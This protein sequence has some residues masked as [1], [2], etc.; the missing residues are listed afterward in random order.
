MLCLS[1]YLYIYYIKIFDIFQ[2]IK[3]VGRQRLELW[4]PAL[5]VL[6][7]TNWAN[8]PNGGDDETRTRVLLE[9]YTKNLILTL[10]AL[11]YI[12]MGQSDDSI[13]TSLYSLTFREGSYI[14]NYH[15]SKSYKRKFTVRQPLLIIRLY[16]L[17]LLTG[18]Y[19]EVT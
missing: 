10:Q 15:N 16:F 8:D 4:T 11:P 5:K 13:P 14:L 2:I 3:M 9:W 19:I 7:S 18:T 6:C 12:Y 17:W 1:F